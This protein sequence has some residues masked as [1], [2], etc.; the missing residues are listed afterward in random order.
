[1]DQAERRI[2]PVDEKK[3]D[4]AIGGKSSTGR[5]FLL[6]KKERLLVRTILKRA[7]KSETGRQYVIE[8]LGAEYV[9]IGEKLIEDME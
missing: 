4:D 3:I 1:V 8:K 2:S 6:G 5:L 7:M 9:A